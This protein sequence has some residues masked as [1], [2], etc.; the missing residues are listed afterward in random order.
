MLVSVLFRIIAIQEV[1]IVGMCLELADVAIVA[2]HAT[3]VGQGG[4][5]ALCTLGGIGI[6]IGIQQVGIGIL[7]VI[8]TTCPL[9]K[10]TGIVSSLLHHLGNNL[11]IHQVRFLTYKTVVRVVAI[12]I[13]SQRTAPILSVATHMGMACMLTCHE[14]CTRG[15]TDRTTG[16]S[17]GEAHTLTGHAVQIGCFYQLLTIASKVAISHIIAHDKYDIGAILLRCIIACRW[18]RTVRYSHSWHHA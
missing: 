14:R 10:H 13:G 16:I 2:I 18:H 3:F 12:H 11:M 8:V 1:G 9:A 4:T 17:L 7:A 15:C 5:A 6:A